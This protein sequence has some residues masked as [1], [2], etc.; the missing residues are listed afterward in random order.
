MTARFKEGGTEKNGAL[1]KQHKQALSLLALKCVSSTADRKKGEGKKKRGGGGSQ[2]H[3]RLHTA[4]LS[5]HGP[6]D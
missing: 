4:S 5:S 3:T 1:E 2:E 6:E